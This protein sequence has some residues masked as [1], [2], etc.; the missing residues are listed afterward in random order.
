LRQTSSAF[1]NLRIPMAET[2]ERGFITH[3]GGTRLRYFATSSLLIAGTNSGTVNPAARA[4]TAIA[5][6]SRKVFAVELLMPGR[7]RCSRASAAT[8]TSNSSSATM[9]SGWLVLAMCATRSRNNSTG[10]SF[11]R[12]KT[13]S[14]TSRGQ[15]S[16][17]IFSLVTSVT[18]QPSTLHSRMKSPPLKKVAKQMI[19]IE[20][21]RTA[22]IYNGSSVRSAIFVELQ[23]SIFSRPVGSEN[24]LPTRRLLN[25]SI[26]S[27]KHRAPPEREHQMIF[28]GPYPE[29]SIP[30]V[31]LTDF[32]FNSTD[33]IKDKPALIDGP[34]GRS[35]TY[36]QFEDAVRRGASSLARRGFKKGD[37]F[38]IFSTN[39]P[40]YG[41]IFH[42]VAML[43]GINTPI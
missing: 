19:F 26:V 1:S 2:S 43:G 23:A 18:L 9:R 14:S 8:T 28:R 12:A 22:S 7:H 3:G 11:G 41:I 40:E 4:F 34:S 35:Y 21:I 13:S 16:G 30:E 27:Y 15:S 20:L 24:S 5:Y 10:A 42:A 38:A 33:Q 32:I 25:L 36:A 39:C 6:L 29:V 17:S 31:S 37:V